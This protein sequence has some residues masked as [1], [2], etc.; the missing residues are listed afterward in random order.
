MIGNFI[1]F[2]SI[3]R[4][5]AG[6]YTTSGILYLLGLPSQ[7]LRSE[8]V[9]AE[10]GA[11]DTYNIQTTKVTMI[12]AFVSDILLLIIMLIGLF[13]DDYHRSDAFGWGRLLWKQVRCGESSLAVVLS[14]NNFFVRE[15]VVWLSLATVAGILPTVSLACSLHF[16]FSHLS[17][18]M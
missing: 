5:L 2:W 13:R 17:S 16:S 9:P 15:G 11:C 1:A 8:W 18:N 6:K 12:V 4:Y 14:L 3:I 10:G 7:Q